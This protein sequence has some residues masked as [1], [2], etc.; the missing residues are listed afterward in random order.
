MSTASTP[1]QIEENA[2]YLM[3]KDFTGPG[4]PRRAGK[5]W[6]ISSVYQNNIKEL[7]NNLKKLIVRLQSIMARLNGGLLT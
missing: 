5:D 6:F 1:W 4:E 2:N 7:F 3:L